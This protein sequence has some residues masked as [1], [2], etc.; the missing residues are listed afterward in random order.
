MYFTEKDS[1]DQI[2]NTC[3]ETLKNNG[4]LCLP[5]DSCYGFSGMAFNSD[6]QNKLVEIKSQSDSKPLSIC[7]ADKSDIYDYLKPNS[8]IDILIEEFLPGPITIISEDLNGEFL[9]VRVPD[10]SFMTTL[11]SELGFPIFTTSANKHKM[12]ACYSIEE[13]KT[14]LGDN[15][16][17][18]DLVIDYG[19]LDF[20]NPSTIIKVSD[21]SLEIV[22]EGDLA[23]LIRQRFVLL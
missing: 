17:K 20:K 19:V 6:S 2:L 8:I 22:R 5:S 21:N 14:Q 11:V 23:E 13:L 9:G 16:S 18:I 10:H 12:P 15:F 7:L 1:F 3:V 4:V